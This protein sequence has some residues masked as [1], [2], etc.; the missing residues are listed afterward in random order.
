MSTS[1]GREIYFTKKLKMFKEIF[2]KPP[3]IEK[4]SRIFI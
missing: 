3:I 2:K 1:C 4:A